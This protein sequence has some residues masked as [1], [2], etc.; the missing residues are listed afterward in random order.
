MQ[1]LKT[2][3]FAVIIG[4]LFSCNQH[5]KNFGETSITKWADNKKGAI[6]ITYDDATINQFRQ[7]LPIMDTLG[8]KG[9]FF[10]NTC[11]IPGSQFAPKWI[12]RS[13]ETIVK[14]TASSP[15]DTT[16]LFERASALRFL[17]IPEAVNL[18]NSAGSLYESGKLQ[19]SLKI[20]DQAFATA[21][22]K[23]A[24]REVRPV[25]L[26]GDLITWPEIKAFAARG[27]EFGNHTIS[28]P[29]LSV[30]TEP[31]ILYELEKCKEEI[32]NQLGPDHIFSAEC[33]FGTENERVMQYAYKIHPALRNRMP[34]PFLGEINRSSSLTP[35]SFNNKEYVQWQ[36][37]PLQKTPLE[38]MKS[39][40][41]T[42]LVRDNVWLVLTFHG[43]DGIGWEA[44]PHERHKAYFSYMK[45]K[46]NDLWVATFKDAT[47]Y[48]RERMNAKVDVDKSDDDK[49]TVRV[50]HS[51]DTALYNFPLTLKTYVDKDW[52]KVSVK[53]GDQT[54]NINTT[55]DENGNYAVYQVMPN[56]GQAELSGVE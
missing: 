32:R 11:D 12:G 20:V 50:I 6:S 19:E 5:D 55:S 39:W 35:S 42:L 48:M 8:F 9:T 26:T 3:F 33:P 51:L 52:K 46:G 13:L 47:K 14:E 1:Q 44:I 38:T 34:E 4:L 23:K 41:D 54:Q 16:N 15:T 29:R 28:H 22:K 2:I 56:G 37:G 18:H 43:V 45:E 49:I 53:Q 10:I 40:V 21:R 36:R 25:L 30:L 27:H 24:Y 17:D 31:N 7:A